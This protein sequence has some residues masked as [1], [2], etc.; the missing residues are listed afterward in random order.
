MSV[1]LLKK[2]IFDNLP[3]LIDYERMQHVRTLLDDFDKNIGRILKIR[4]T[5]LEIAGE[6]LESHSE[7]VQIKGSTL[8]V[9]CDAPAWVQQIDILGP[10]LC[11][12]I[13]RIAGIKIKCIEGRFG[14][15]KK[16]ASR[17][18]W[19]CPPMRPDI[20]P[21][22]VER[23]KDPELREKVKALLNISGWIHG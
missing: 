11:S 18:Q 19:F 23:I 17:A 12:Q 8:Q 20:D 3:S 16:P 5:W 21:E 2:N 10:T 14:I 6:I 1:S 13:K 22:A 9:N 4:S 7:P 15:I